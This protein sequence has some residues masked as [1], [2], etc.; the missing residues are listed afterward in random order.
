MAVFA[1]R[2]LKVGLQLLHWEGGVEGGT[3]RWSDLLDL[4]RRAEAV[5]FDSL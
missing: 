5:G 3:P 2:P 1:G 4:A